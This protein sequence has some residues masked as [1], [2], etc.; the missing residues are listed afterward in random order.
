MPRIATSINKN[1]LEILKENV[2]FKFNKTF[3]K[4]ID[5][6]ALSKDI[7]IETNELIN[8]ISLKRLFGFV[9]SKFNPSNN[10]LDILS[11]YIGAKNWFTYT[12][13][14]SKEKLISNDELRLILSAYDFDTINEITNYDG[15]IQSV[16]RKFAEKLRNSPSSFLRISEALAKNKNSQI[17][18]IEHFPD[19]DNLIP[20]YY[21]IFEQYLKYKKTDEAQ[22]FG[23]SILFLKSFWQN[24]K[25]DCKNYI[26]KVNKIG[27]SLNYHP[28]VIGRFY[29]V[30]LL[31]TYFYNGKDVDFLTH[32][33]YETAEQMPKDGKHF[34]DFPAFQYI[35]S[36]AFL[37]IK[38][39]YDVLKIINQSCEN[40]KIKP[41]FV[42]KG[43]YRQ[44][45]MFKAE[46]LWELGDKKEAE[47]ILNKVNPNKFYFFSKKYYT[48]IYLILKYKIKT[49]N[50]SYN[51]A[52][53]IIKE[54]ENDFLMNKLNLH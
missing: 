47:F 11:K 14:L 46:A 53:R 13:I 16:S 54:M 40:Y 33:I 37:H 17:F 29:A 38:K 3:S 36:E 43:Y 41:E 34:K 51:M 19:Y 9:E 35:I 42:K 8:A 27:V 15:G 10:T 31:Y 44:M 26:K 50:N 32:K 1:N 18:F 25:N 48:A 4:P 39:Y 30:N 7:L 24:N 5:C 45:Q 52:K 22:V 49:D 2:I 28:Y 23:N 21:K 20:F 12:E 6:E